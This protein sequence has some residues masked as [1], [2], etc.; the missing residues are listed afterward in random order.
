MKHLLIYAI[1]AIWTFS[2]YA[3]QCDIT[4]GKKTVVN[5][6]KKHKRQKKREIYENKTE[7][8]K[9]LFIEP[10]FLVEIYSNTNLMFSIG[11]INYDV[12]FT[13]ELNFDCIGTFVLNI[14]KTHIFAISDSHNS[15]VTFD[16]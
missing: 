11:L 10:Q 2:C 4:Y 14:C 9:I 3:D 8:C 6:G 16:V 7:K 1:L 5:A 13:G 15:C 12:C